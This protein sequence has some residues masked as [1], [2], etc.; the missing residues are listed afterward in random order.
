MTFKISDVSFVNQ[1]TK[2][3]HQTS[4]SHKMPHGLSPMIVSTV[5]IL[6]LGGQEKRREVT[7]EHVSDNQE[8]AECNQ[9]KLRFEKSD[10]FET[11]YF[12]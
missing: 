11:R 10:E 1:E 6:G 5:E 7:Q 2:K 12:I 3:K 8:Q 4:Y 9:G